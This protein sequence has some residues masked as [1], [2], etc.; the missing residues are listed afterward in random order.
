MMFAVQFTCCGLDN[1]SA[2][3]DSWQ[4]ADDLRESY[5]DAPGHQ[6]SAIIRL[7]E[8]SD[9]RTGLVSTAPSRRSRPPTL[10]A[11]LRPRGTHLRWR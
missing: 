3:R 4:E 10:L 2:V 6:R 5:L 7:A 11:R 8:D 1:G 9:P